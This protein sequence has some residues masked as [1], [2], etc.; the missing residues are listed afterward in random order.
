MALRRAPR[1][2][3]A[4]GPESPDLLL[5]LDEETFARRTKRWALLVRG[6]GAEVLAGRAALSAGQAAHR[7][8][9]RGNRNNPLRL[10]A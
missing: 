3:A 8:D 7:N 9:L 4:L 1:L 2:R 10:G 5:E 6:P